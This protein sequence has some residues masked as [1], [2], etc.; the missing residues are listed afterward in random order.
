MKWLLTV[1]A[2]SAN[3]ANPRDLNDPAQDIQER[4]EAWWYSGHINDALSSLKK[5][6]D[7]YKNR[8]TTAKRRHIVE[9]SII[10]IVPL[11]EDINPML[12][13]ELNVHELSENRI[14]HIMED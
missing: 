8:K 14:K 12:L 10:S 2:W 13:A 4:T 11:P 3:V 1:R 9:Y 5:Y 7:A 6:S